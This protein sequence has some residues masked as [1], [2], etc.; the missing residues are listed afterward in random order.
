MTKKDYYEILSV[1]RTAS[2]DE[3]KTSYRKMAMKYHPDRNPGNHEAEEMFKECAE[4]YEILSDPTKRQ[5]Y[6]QFGHQGVTGGPGG[7]SGFTDM[8]DIFSHFG[9]IFGGGQGGSIFDEFFGGGGRNSQ[10][11][12]QGGGVRGSDLKISLKLTL[13][14]IAD[15]IEKTIKVKK[16]KTCETCK[17]TGAKGESGF[18]KC[19]HCNGSG[20][21]RQVSRSIFGQFVNVTMC[22]VC[23]GEGRVVKEKCSDCH[24]EGRVKTEAEIK[25]NI[26][27]GVSDGNYIPLEGQGNAGMR[28]GPAGDLYIHLEEEVHSIFQREEDDIYYELDLSLVDA[29]IGADV[30]VPTLKG[31]AKL[32]I[33]AGTQPGSILKM[34][35]KGIQRLHS[36]RRGDQLVR[37]NVH[38]P[39]KLSGK[40]KDTLREL[41]KSENFQPQTGKKKSSKGFFKKVFTD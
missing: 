18:T 34:S 16:Q 41:A 15:G 23:H 31:K 29:A 20:E 19:A 38:I 30:I 7:F 33:D 24:G 2:G 17:G 27:S 3:I 8:N 13:E 4:A 22:D 26:P 32:K 28:G 5:R 12:K 1:E 39:T 35:H 37:I 10:R 14:E 6:D 11:R 25:V 9:D 40:E 36:D 21:V